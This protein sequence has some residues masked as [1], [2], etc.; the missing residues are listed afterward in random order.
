VNPVNL[1]NS[2]T[3]ARFLAV[4]VM[5]WLIS[6]DL[7]AW[8]FWLFIAAGV[9]D[10]LD[11]FLARLLH[12]HTEIGAYLDPLA[13]KALL[14]GVYVTLGYYDH[15]PSWLVLTVVSRDIFIV[16]G[17][18]LFELTIGT[19]EIQPLYISKVNTVTQIILASLVLGGPALGLDV[20]PLIVIM[21]W[22]VAATTVASGLNYLHEWGIHA[23]AIRNGHGDSVRTDHEP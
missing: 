5:V 7:L 8:A 2:L 15:I 20:S 1:P 16:G 17:A 4:P 3:I 21:I 19:W 13:D 18:I 10:A 22:V 23:Q 9:T 11:G 12:A 14:V 6:E